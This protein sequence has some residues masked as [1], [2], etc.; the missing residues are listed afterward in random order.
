[1]TRLTSATVT[2]LSCSFVC[3][4]LLAAA[5]AAVAQTLTAN[6]TTDAFSIDR[7]DT[8]TITTS[9]PSTN[10]VGLFAVGAGNSTGPSHG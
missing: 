8:V 7:G 6:G 3:L 10:W 1:M 4:L 2:V 9:G 5:D